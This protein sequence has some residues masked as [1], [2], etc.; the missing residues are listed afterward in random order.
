MPC[1]GDHNPAKKSVHLTNSNRNRESFRIVPKAEEFWDGRCMMGPISVVYDQKI[2]P[3]HEAI[4]F[5]PARSDP[6][7]P[8][9][10]YRSSSMDKGLAYLKKWLF[11]SSGN[12]STEPNLEESFMLE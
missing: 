1:H 5:S 6:G 12:P 2:L 8:V 4:P 11:G 10:L 9:P 7:Q 3:T